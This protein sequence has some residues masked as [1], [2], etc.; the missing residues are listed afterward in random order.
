M[1]KKQIS[2]YE[3]LAALVGQEIGVSDWLEVTQDMING[4]AD[5]TLDHQWIHVDEA[6]C[7]AESPYGCTIAHGYLTLSLLPYLWN[8]IVE[9]T[10][11]KMQVN[12]GINDFKFGDAVKVG[13]CVCLRAKLEECLDLRGITKCTIN[14]TMEIEGNRKPAYK[15]NVVFLYHFNK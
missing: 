10:N 12:Y 9:V 14:V 5:S 8:Q 4:F 7:K 6:K 11:L 2:S 1:E 3:S 15:G 13:S